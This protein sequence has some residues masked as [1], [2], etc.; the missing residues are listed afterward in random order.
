MV[1]NPCTQFV[2]LVLWDFLGRHRKPHTKE[3]VFSGGSFPGVLVFSLD[4][5]LHF[6][7]IY[8]LL[9]PQPSKGADEFCERR[10]T[11]RRFAF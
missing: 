9:S 2:H 1:R 3:G 5:A 11:A 6:G 4:R 10:V 8:F 7:C